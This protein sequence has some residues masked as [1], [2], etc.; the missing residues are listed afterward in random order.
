[1]TKKSIFGIYANLITNNSSSP[2]EQQNTFLAAFATFKSDYRLVMSVRPHGTRLPPDR[3]PW[4]LIFED[5]SKK[6][7]CWRKIQVWFKMWQA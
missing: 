4:N 6:K 3:L 1:M 7:I 2:V 5:F